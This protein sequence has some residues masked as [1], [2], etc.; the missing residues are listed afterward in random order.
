MGILGA[1]FNLNTPG[2][3]IQWGVI[4]ISVANIVVILIMLVLFGLALFL[5][6]PHASALPKSPV[7]SDTDKEHSNVK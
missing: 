7:K 6:F 4:D 1:L 2:Y 5:P 3:F